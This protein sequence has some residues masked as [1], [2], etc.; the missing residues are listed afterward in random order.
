MLRVLKKEGIILWYDFSYDN[1]KNPDVK[2]I[3][4]E[5]IIN[6][7]PNCKFTFNKVTLAPPIVRSTAPRSW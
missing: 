3:K 4:K 7:F 6:L 1:P 2:G 5:E